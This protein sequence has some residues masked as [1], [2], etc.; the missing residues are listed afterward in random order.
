MEDLK[1]VIYRPGIIANG[2]AFEAMALIYKYLQREY[3]WQFTIIKDERDLFQ[4]SEL[5]II[6]VPYKSRET[7]SITPILKNP[8]SFKRNVINTLKGYDLILGCDPTIYSQ[9]VHAAYAAKKWSTPLVYDASLTIMGAGRSLFWKLQKRFANWSLN[10]SSLIWVTAP[11]TAERFRDLGCVDER[12][13]SQFVILGHPVDTEI[14]KP[15][16]G[17]KTKRKTIICVARLVLEKGIQY[18]IEAMVPI[19]REDKEV[20]LKIVGSGSAKSF[21][22]RLIDEEG[23]NNNV[24]FIDPVPHSELPKLYQEAGIFIGHPVSVSDWEEFFGVVHVEAMACGLPVITTKCGG[25][26]HLAREDVFSLVE[27]RDVVST[28]KEIKK[29]LYN[30]EFYYQRSMSGV[31]YVNRNYSLKVIAEKYRKYLLKLLK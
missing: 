23:L 11:K 25:I 21:L 7:V 9:G 14:F 19:I 13:I 5:N 1:I 8:I 26:T 20:E 17:V 22:Q 18:I 28:T 10:K 4:D 27:E 15:Q 16:K 29:L 6:T 12:I 24:E 30:D 3:G 31:E 2:T